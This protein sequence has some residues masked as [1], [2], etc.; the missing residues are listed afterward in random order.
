M[1]GS[2]ISEFLGAIEELYETHRGTLDGGVNG[3]LLRD[4]MPNVAGHRYVI[5]DGLWNLDREPN[6]R[7]VSSLLDLLGKFAPEYAGDITRLREASGNGTPSD[8]LLLQILGNRQQE[9]AAFITRLGISSDFMSFFS[10]VAA[11]GYRESVARIV[12]E[13]EDL[14]NYFS[15]LCPVCGHWPGISYIMQKSGKKKMACL[16]CGAVWSFR[17]MRCSFCLT[18]ER[19]MLS[20]LDVEGEEQVSAYTCDKCRRYLKTVKVDSDYIDL[21]GNRPF[22]DYL[23]S[24]PVDLA[25]LREKYVQESLLG[26]RF[27][28]PGDEKLDHYIY[29]LEHGEGSA[30][31]G[32][33]TDE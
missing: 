13:T 4:A 19:D 15:G 30:V 32:G 2:D 8:S 25:A 27:D 31:A 14:D 26:T 23:E 33:G 17:R 11:R 20:Y 24:G 1:S 3:D 28:G 16:C 6:Y 18:S 10:I 22:L 12:R 7:Y 21:S 9:L 5:S 29:E